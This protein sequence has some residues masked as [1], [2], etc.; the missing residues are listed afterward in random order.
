MNLNPKF[1]AELRTRL[2]QAVEAYRT[3]GRRFEAL[4]AAALQKRF[5]LALKAWCRHQDRSDIA[6]ELNDLS[7]EFLSRRQDVPTEPMIEHL[8][9][10]VPNPTTHA[11]EPVVAIAV[12]ILRE[13]TP[14]GV[15]VIYAPH[16]GCVM[17]PNPDR[18]GYDFD[19]HAE[20]PA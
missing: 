20:E 8:A 9:V 2:R 1:I 16:W 7:C 15:P 4:D 13:S 19:R 5:V 10:F 14:A 11:A 17:T 18:Y 3:G 12:V 6:R